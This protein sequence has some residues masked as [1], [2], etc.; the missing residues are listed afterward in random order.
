MTKLSNEEQIAQLVNTSNV[1]KKHIG[2]GT[3]IYRP[4]YGEYKTSRELYKKLGYPIILWS[5]DTLDWKTKDA[6][7]TVKVILDNVKDGDIVLMHDIHKETADA[8]KI[9]V[10]E[11]KKRGYQLVTI[12][13]LASYRKQLE[14]GKNYGN[15]RKK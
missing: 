4:P 10:P 9:L 8:V 11:L 7:N 15:F 12:S 2:V 5:I 1:V 14:P 6:N 3:K 13:E